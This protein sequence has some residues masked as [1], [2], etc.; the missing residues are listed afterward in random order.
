MNKSV[1]WFVLFLSISPSRLVNAQNLIPKADHI[2]VAILENHSY[3]QIIGSKDAPY[4]NSLANDTLSA[5]FT[6]S[7]AVTHPSQPNYLILYSGSTQGV[8][9][10]LIPSE[11]PFA[12]ANLGRQLIDAGKTFI[13]YSEDLESVG[14]NGSSSGDYARKH[15]PAANWMGT[16]LNQVPTT[17]NQPFTAFPSDNFALL[18]TISFVVPNLIHDMHDGADPARITTGDDWISH[19]LDRYIQWAKTH[20]C[21]FI[22]TFDE[23]LT[24]DKNRILTIIT[25]QMVKAGQYSDKITHYSILHTLESIYGLPMVGDSLSYKP[26]SFCWKA[27]EFSSIS[28]ANN[29]N[30]LIYPN[31]CREWLN[32]KISNYQNAIAEIYTMEGQL[33]WKNTLASTN[34]PIN[35]EA[36]VKGAYLLKITRREGI[37]VFKFLKS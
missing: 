37:T 21:L 32:I 23:G 4:I 6:N 18:P 11:I 25:G 27:G 19:N 26:I 22:L 5:L 30:D 28:P 31:P 14:F 2:V 9:D 8:T 7:Y 35:T 12:T 10:D 1:F 16:G 3:T 17:T 15:N 20:N 29:A 33:I 13:T 34:T 36:L 24:A